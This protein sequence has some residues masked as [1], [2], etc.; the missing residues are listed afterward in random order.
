MEELTMK[1]DSRIPRSVAHAS[2][3]P[4]GDLVDS[5]QDRAAK[6][7]L[8]ALEASL[9]A[10]SSAGAEGYAATALELAALAV[11]MN[12]MTGD[13]AVALKVL[14]DAAPSPPYA[15]NALDRLLAATDAPAD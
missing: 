15:L 2:A 5:V 11:Q 10:G 6:A 1:N 3:A 9:T 14:R 8:K 13:L 7:S 4:V 12:R